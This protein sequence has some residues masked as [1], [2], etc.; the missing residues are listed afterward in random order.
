MDPVRQ[1]KFSVLFTLY[2]HIIVLVILLST[3]ISNIYLL[4]HNHT[5]EWEAK[6]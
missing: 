3:D 6:L 2:I 1:D 4:L 5:R